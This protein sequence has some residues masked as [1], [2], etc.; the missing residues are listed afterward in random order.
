MKKIYLI[1]LLF[2]ISF[3]LFTSCNDDDFLDVPPQYVLTAET[4]ITDYSKA[5]NAVGGI[6]YSFR[7]DSWAGGY[8]TDL[9]TK[10]GFVNMAGGQNF[11]LIYTQESSAG[12]AHW[13]NFYKSLNNAN[14]AIKGIENLP[15]SIFPSQTAKNEL[16]AE[17]RFLRAFI[18]TH[19]LWNFGYW[20]AEDDNP[21]G[22]LYRDQP[23]DL[24]NVTQARIS[25]GES[26]SGIYQDIDFAIA[27]LTDFTTPRH[28]SRQFAQAF[29]AKVLLYRAGVTNNAPELQA[30]LGLVNDALAN[31]PTNLHIEPDM[32]D[33]YAKAWDNSEN[34]FVRY[35]DN[36]GQR[37]SSG[38]DWYTYGFAQRVGDVLPLPPGGEL[39]AG[40]LYGLDWFTADPRW[41]I[42]TGAVRSSV[43]WDQTMRWT[44][45][46][47]GR[48]GR[49]AGQQ[50][51]P[52]DD[53]FATYFMRYPELLIM[54]SEL[55]ART[56]S[57]IAEAI[58]P[59]NQMRAARTNP[60]LPALN[61]ANQEELMDLIFREYFLE[62]FM[63]N[64]NE[65]FAA[66]RFQ[67]DGQPYIVSIKYGLPFDITHLCFPIH[68]AEM[69]NNAKMVQNP[70]LE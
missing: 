39:T 13:Q 58:S 60:V 35:L 64:G 17:A 46:K 41:E 2:L 11:N 69:I 19:I 37:W 8:G 52:Q 23:S 42:A 16:L 43:A 3:L 4:A 68:D 63:E 26:Y 48:S 55:M 21:Y 32:D 44:W 20:W 50:A 12:R 10:A 15:E 27:N 7:N 65:L 45:K 51:S 54:K 14:F 18:H 62:T 66:V 40:L 5:K 30:A 9:A 31:T 56:G 59:I 67:K 49:Y 53:L 24:A 25:V 47:L 33:V 61:P 1:Q 29:K 70:G 6:Y 22:L 34:L 38:G 28:V 57:T 36:D